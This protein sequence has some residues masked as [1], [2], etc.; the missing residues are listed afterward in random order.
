MAM[1][2]VMN[3]L[4]PVVI[5]PVDLNLLLGVDLVSIFVSHCI[6]NIYYFPRIS[7]SVI[8]R[9]CYFHYRKQELTT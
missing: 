7:S 5:A 1:I 9:T 4:E 2:H 3:L 6:I 8:E